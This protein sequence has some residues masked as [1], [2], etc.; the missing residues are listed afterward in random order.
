MLYR[1]DNHRYIEFLTQPRVHPATPS[2]T[3][4]PRRLDMLTP[5][6]ARPLPRAPPPPPPPPPAPPPTTGPPVWLALALL[7][8]AAAALRGHSQKLTST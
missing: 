6:A 4:R 3:W 1:K 5:F 2:P 8:A 7:A